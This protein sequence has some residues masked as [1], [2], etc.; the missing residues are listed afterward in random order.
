M[1]WALKTNFLP[2]LLILGKG[3]LSR[4]QREETII[5][6]EAM[7]VWSLDEQLTDDAGNGV[8]GGQGQLRVAQNGQQLGHQAHA[9][10]QLTVGL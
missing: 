5:P 4:K 8:G 3:G 1:D 6:Q 10:H 2:S 7:W 9:S